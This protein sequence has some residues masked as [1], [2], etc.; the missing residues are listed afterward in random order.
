[1]PKKKRTYNLKQFQGSSSTSQRPNAGH[2]GSDSPTTTVNE[3]LEDLR[4][5]Q[6]LDA[7]QKKRDIAEL[8]SQRS[9][10]PEL[11]GI[12]GVPET[13]PPKP[14]VGIRVRDRERMRSPGP[15]GPAPPKSWLGFLPVW[16]SGTKASDG[17]RKGKKAVSATSVRNRPEKLMRFTQMVGIDGEPHGLLHLTLKRLAEQWDLLDDEDLPDLIEI[18]SRL[19][20]RLLTYL[21]Y[22]GPPVGA[23]ALRALTQGNNAITYLDLG[24]LAGHGPLTLKRLIRVLEQDTRPT[25]IDA[26]A[27]GVLDS[28]DAEDG[29]E[30]QLSSQPAA[31]SF[32]NLTHLC[33]SN[34]PSTASWREL[35][36]LSKHVP[37]L[38]HLSL[39]YWPRPTLTPHLATAT[40]QSSHSPEVRAGGSHYYSAM[41]QDFSEP[42]SL[43]RQLSCNLLCLQWLD[44]EGCAEWVP[45]LAT[46]AAAASVDTAGE[47]GQDNDADRW[48]VR[49][50][51][52][53]IF[54][55]TWR[56]VTYL[57][58][59]QGW[60]PSSA[61]IEGL[62]TTSADRHIK[63]DLIKHLRQH[64]VVPEFPSHDVHDV[65]K[66]KARLWMD[67][68]RRLVAAADRINTI[69]RVRA[70]K[71]VT[72]DYGWR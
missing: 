25:A 26:Q 43:L 23:L 28:W 47:E 40:V 53:K 51:V 30:A 1:M 5:D 69:R 22:Y 45:A 42:A 63:A 19:R 9:V 14:K 13:A 50:N 46:L 8:V 20:L 58:C 66:R 12:L 71:L 3:R 6:S 41:D 56:N 24:G 62:A 35:L 65:E 39:A 55:D 38:T 72:V 31:F 15:P 36:A 49:P 59:S 10:P 37:Q 48:Y 18:P 67:H 68:E 4:K 11:R 32:A 16:Q 17:K 44:L 7:A 70:C 52:M 57:N 64:D 29:T 60:L 61:G 27:E 21:G 54:T 33:L 2:D 34:P